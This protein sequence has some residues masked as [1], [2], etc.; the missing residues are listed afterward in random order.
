MAVVAVQVERI[1][2]VWTVCLAPMDPRS[3]KIHPPY[4]GVTHHSSRNDS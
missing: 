2:E 4:I 1:G 3:E